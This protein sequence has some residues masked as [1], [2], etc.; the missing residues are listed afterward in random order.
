[1]VDQNMITV[2]ERFLNFH[3]ELKQTC[4]ELNRNT[5]EICVVAVSKLQNIS[6]IHEAYR[7]G[8]F[9]FGE[10]Y[11]QE[12][13]EKIRTLQIS[14]LR[15]HLI[16]PLQSNKINKVLGLFCLIHSVD[17][18][19]LAVE[20]NER[21]QKKN[22]KQSVLLQFNFAGEQSK[23]GFS[24]EDFEGSWSQ[25]KNLDSLQIEGLMTMPPLNNPEPSFQK[26]QEIANKYNFKK[27]SM[28]TTSDWKLA[29]KYGSTHI[30]IGTALFGER[31]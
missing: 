15:W 8:H 10:N 16:G 18:L 12:A 27:L 3:R 31:E 2:T 9:D 7:N 5:K 17:S 20:L 4:D 19:K 6:K 29:L 30:R 24:I 26:A 1:M 23:S 22:L 28:G 13:L 21:A 14:E 25:L 11:V